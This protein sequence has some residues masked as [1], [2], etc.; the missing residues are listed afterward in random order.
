[1]DHRVRNATDLDRF[2]DAGKGETD[3]A[4]GAVCVSD[5][6]EVSSGSSKVKVEPKKGPAQ[7]RAAGGGK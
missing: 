6:G 4:E 7:K 1:M 3:L 2:K 5:D